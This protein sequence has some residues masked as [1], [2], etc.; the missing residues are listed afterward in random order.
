MEMVKFSVVLPL[1]G[2][3]LYS[4]SA[5]Y[6]LIEQRLRAESML[7]VSFYTQSWDDFAFDEE[8]IFLLFL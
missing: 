8:R 7:R 4:F 5:K 3:F 1:G 2:D 6:L